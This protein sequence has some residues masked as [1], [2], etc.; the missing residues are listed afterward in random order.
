MWPNFAAVTER[1]STTRNRVAQKWSLGFLRDASSGGPKSGNKHKERRHHTGNK[2]HTNLYTKLKNQCLRKGNSFESFIY[3]L[4]YFYI[5]PFK[6]IL[7]IIIN[8]H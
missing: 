6:T 5:V 2:M 3:V 7:F 4:N 8:R 1:F